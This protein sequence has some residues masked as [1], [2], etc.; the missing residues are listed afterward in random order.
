MKYVSINSERAEAIEREVGI[1]F[2][3]VDG[4]IK[5][6]HIP[7]GD[8]FIK[9]EIDSYSVKVIEPAPLPKAMKFRVAGNVMDFIIARDFDHYHEAESA[10]QCYR[11]K[12]ADPADVKLEIQEVEVSVN[13]DGTYADERVLPVEEIPF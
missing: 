7:V 13:T 1:Q 8:S 9:V 2:K 6:I 12:A 10:I 3:Y 5:G 11:T 4:N